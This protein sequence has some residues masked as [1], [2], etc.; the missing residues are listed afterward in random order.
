MC[1]LETD[2]CNDYDTCPM[3]YLKEHPKQKA[4]MLQAQAREKQA[5][6]EAKLE[7]KCFQK[8]QKK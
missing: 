6:K 4:E 5:Q 7:A 8:E 3:K 1:N 2:I